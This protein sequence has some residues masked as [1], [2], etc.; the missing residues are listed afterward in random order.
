MGRTRCRTLAA[1]S[2]LILV[3]FLIRAGTLDAQSLW[4]DEVDSL[5]FATAPPSEL[6]SSFTRH[7]WN[8]PLYHLVLRGWIAFTGTS[9]YAMRFLTLSFGVLAVPLI[10]AIGRRLFD[11]LTGIVSAFLVTGSP[12]LVWYSQE[13]KMYTL[14]LA[15]ALLA[16]YSLRRALDG[17]SW[18]WWVSQFAATTLALYVHIL[19]AL[20]IPVQMLLCIAWWSRTRLRWRPALISFVC[21]TLPYLPLLA[22]QAPLALQTRDTG[23]YPYSLSQ[24]IV[25][26]LN[27]WATGI[28]GWGRAWAAV[29]LSLLAA[30]TLLTGAARLRPSPASGD[31]A[32]PDTTARHYLA[33]LIWLVVPLLAIWLISLRQPLF[34][35]RY[36]IWSASPFY[37]LVALA[38]TR[39]ARF[40][41]L[42]R[43][44]TALLLSVVLVVDGVNVLAQ[45]TTPI[46]SDF[47][48]AAHYVA[49]YQGPAGSGAPP[50]SPAPGPFRC[51]LPIIV[52]GPSAFNDLIIF[53][54]PYGEY[55]FDYY[56]PIE[57][58]P[59]AEGLYTNHR[60]ADGGYLLSE[61]EAA[62]R[63]REMTDGYNAVWLIATEMATWDQ[64]NLVQHWLDHH[65]HRSAEA[66][67]TRVDVYRYTRPAP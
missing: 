27:A 1:I 67:F 66:N 33:L 35:D 36:L 57:N 52:V 28:A 49:S 43:W 21:L 3:A 6:L 37:L 11:P 16:V 19:A 7:G 41:S 58:Y 34:T 29:L 32:P 40:N 2:L 55:T 65:F 42:G 8:G 5:R 9:E 14:V 38:L 60:A 53:Q 12:Y 24:M 26:L 46:K 50:P 23:F 10:Y 30:G 39:L 63:M 13:V 59:Q 61:Q 54:I 20:L 47:R 48:A 22:W 45:A 56:F 62:W 4:R 25:I 51:Y 44:V 64:R 17:G 31:Q 15:L 18:L